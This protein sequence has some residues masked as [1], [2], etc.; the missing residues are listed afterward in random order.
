MILIYDGMLSKQRAETHAAVA[1][2]MEAQST[3]EDIETLPML[4]THWRRAGRPSKVVSYLERVA[5]LRLRQFDNAGAITLLE[6]FCERV[7]DPGVPEDRMR[8]ARCL[9]MLGKAHSGLGKMVEAEVAFREGLAK[10]DMRL[11]SGR[12]ILALE[13]CRQMV[14][15]IR[16]RRSARSIQILRPD[17][18]E[19]L[20]EDQQKA[21]MAAEAHEALMQIFYFSGQKGRLLHSALSAANLA[22]EL[23]GATPGLAVNTAGLGAI[24]GVIP[25]RKQAA[26]Y[27]KRASDIAEVLDVPS[28][29]SRVNLFSGLYETAVADW[30]NAERAFL[31]GMTS[32][33]AIR[34]KRL[35]CEHAVSFE[36]ICSPWSLTH[37]FQ[38]VDAWEALLDRLEDISL[39]RN[40]TQVQ[41][42][43]HLARVRGNRSMGRKTNDAKSR[44]MLERLLAPTSPM[45][46]LIHYAEGA[47][48][49]A[50][51]AFESGD[52]DVGRA[53]MGMARQQMADLESG[54]KSR[55][56]PALMAVFDACLRQYEHGTAGDRTAAT[57]LAAL[58]TTK[59]RTFA[60]IYPIGRPY[61]YLC[62]G[63]L[64]ALGG[65][66]KAAVRHWRSGL[67]E[68][69]RLK[70]CT[71]AASLS[72]RLS[73]VGAGDNGSLSGEARLLRQLAADTPANRE[74]FQRIVSAA[75]DVPSALKGKNRS[76]AYTLHNN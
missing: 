72:Q 28:A 10:L 46:E 35:W 70:M 45:L 1:R 2:E 7:K 9:I 60:R 29:S 21:E 43:A 75:V 27:L 6:E 55:T 41:A 5:A 48:L 63:D 31:E 18:G 4:L 26:Y 12:R 24:C 37:A 33:D 58:V 32:A 57:E 49:L 67:S 53:W 73:L 68:A 34:D 52:K 17:A 19:M 23:G 56:L 64:A 62:K 40:D 13:L 61:L 47:G 39:D 59:L 51:T 30:K 25:L 38:G 22:G 20:S 44:A 42:C 15:Q 65:K 54:M 3:A 69:M 76:V 8:D 16:Q 66:S 14:R 36:L 11:P 71:A 50:A 74:V